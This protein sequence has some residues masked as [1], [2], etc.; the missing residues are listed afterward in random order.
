MMLSAVKVVNDVV[1]EAKSISKIYPGTLAL[2]QV[3]L[4]IYR[5]KVNVLIGENGA[6]KSTLMKIIAGVEKPSKGQ[7]IYQ[8]EEV[9]F[10][11]TREAGEAG[12]GI[13][14]QE[15]NLFPNLTVAQNIFMAR[16]QT[17]FGRIKNE[18]HK[19]RTK[20]VLNKLEQAIDPDTIV[21]ELRVG[22]Q[23]IIEIAKTMIQKELSILI[24]DEPT[25]SL[26]GAEVK[27]LFELIEELKQQGV[28][29]VYISHRMEEIMQIGDYLTIL[30]DGKL[31]ATAEVKSIDLPWIVRNMV[32][33][34]KKKVAKK[35]EKSHGKEI[36]KVEN[37]VLP[38]EGGL[39]LD[40][41]SF[42][43]HEGEVLGIYGLLG[44]GRTELLESLM[45]QN[46]GDLKGDIYVN[47]KLTKPKSV[48]QQI[49]NG[50]AYIPEDRQREGLVQT[51]SI[52]KNLTLSS[53]QKY[54]K[55]FHLIK[56]QEENAVKKTIKDFFIKVSNSS[57][58][59][60]SL[61][62]GNQQKVVIGKAIL[63][64]PKIL[65]LDE[66]TRGIDISAKADVFEIVNKL[67][68]DGLGVILVSSELT[69]I[70][71]A[72][73]RVIVLCK[74]KL[75]RELSGDEITEQSL[76]EAATIGK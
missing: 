76:M 10:N 36:L 25:S 3:D 51:L 55:G 56:S 52:A 47:G 50:F 67:A 60:L 2:D 41:I 27:V 8:G 20:E 1:L 64:S 30:R 74:G 43:L 48:A 73:D 16:E 24:M 26:S 39:A 33:H 54:T 46:Y 9:S 42:S 49:E 62:G 45:G 13:I 11:N 22:Q 17:K 19:R 28:A 12:I 70:I 29:I 38:K 14:H 15:L 40:H 68:K 23:Q 65:L 21:G 37:L 4:K 66:P 32:G 35:K 6:G 72:S 53:M 44:A 63:T 31:V 58:P 18:E 71:D 69:E 7:I 59:I 75:T 5:G 61:S 34:D 57:L